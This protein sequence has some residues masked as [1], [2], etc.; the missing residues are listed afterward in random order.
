MRRANKSWM[1]AVAGI[2]LVGTLVGVVW[3]RPHDRPQAKDITRKVT[4]AGADFIPRDD[5]DNWWSNGN[6]V[7]C[8]A[9]SCSYHAP[10]VFPCLPSVTVE[11]VKLHVDDANATAYATASLMRAYPRAGG[12][13]YLATVASPYQASG[14]IKTYSSSDINQVVWPSQRAY[15][16]LPTHGPNV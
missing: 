8:Q 3:A 1:A 14:F 6:Y 11:R 10:V 7:M 12:V 5:A 13:I 16:S 15:V 4:L 9:D 2:L